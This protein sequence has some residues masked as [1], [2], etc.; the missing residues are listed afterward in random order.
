MADTKLLRF[1]EISSIGLCVLLRAM[2]IWRG[3]EAPHAEHLKP[4][5]WIKRKS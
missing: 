5:T 2:A 3:W 4:N 1:A